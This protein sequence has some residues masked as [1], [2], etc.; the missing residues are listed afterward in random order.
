MPEERIESRGEHGEPA[1]LPAD[2][3]EAVRLGYEAFNEGDLN[4]A[5]A[6]LGPDFEWVPPED[7][8]TAGTYRGPREVRAEVAAWTDPF[9]DFRWEIAE[10]I[11]AGEHIVV[12]GNMSGRGKVSG[13]PVSLEEVHVWTV[14]D[15]RPVRMQMYHDRAKGFAAAG[16]EA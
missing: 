14:R 16:L 15:G 7:S 2:P 8:L 5:F 11:D 10:V 13:A 6:L 3:V 9:K 1:G 12:V 4:Q